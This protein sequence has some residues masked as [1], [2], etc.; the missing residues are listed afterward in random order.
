MLLCPIDLC[1]SD[2]IIRTTKFM[3]LGMLPRVVLLVLV[4]MAPLLWL[5]LEVGTIR[6]MTLSHSLA[7]S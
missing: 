1:A 5:L 4:V 6:M 7:D 2:G 3:T